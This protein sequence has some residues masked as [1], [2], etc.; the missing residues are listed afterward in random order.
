MPGRCRCSLRTCPS[1][2]D[3]NNKPEQTDYGTAEDEQ[4]VTKLFRETGE[5]EPHMTDDDVKQAI[6]QETN[7][8]GFRRG[9]EEPKTEFQNTEEKSIS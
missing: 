1:K 9:G 2:Q 3:K 7:R 5:T 6:F 4:R 8:N